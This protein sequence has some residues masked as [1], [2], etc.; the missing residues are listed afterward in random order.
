MQVREIMT[1]G[2][3]LIDP[4]MPLREVAKR[5]RVENLGALPIGEND[6][7][8]GMITDRDIVVR[9]VADGKVDGTVARE[10]MSEKVYYCFEEDDLDDAADVMAEHQ[11]RRLPVLDEGK[12]LVGMVSLADLGLSGSSTAARRALQGVSEPSDTDRR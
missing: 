1:R 7:L 5:M 11:V 6:R 4:D 10:V 9:G 3:E 12:R 8:I 2:A